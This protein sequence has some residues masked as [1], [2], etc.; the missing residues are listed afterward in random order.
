MTEKVRCWKVPKVYIVE[1]C[2]EINAADNMS[3]INVLE[4]ND[5]YYLLLFTGFYPFV[6][7]NLSNKYP[8]INASDV[9]KVLELRGRYFSLKGIVA[10]DNVGKLMISDES[11]FTKQATPEQVK[12]L[13]EKWQQEFMEVKSALID[14]SKQ[15]YILDL[16]EEGLP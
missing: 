7:S 9:D 10:D 1:V 16:P 6:E 13:K 5:K 4:Y 3:V 11:G 8:G 15:G 12:S 14:Y 2:N